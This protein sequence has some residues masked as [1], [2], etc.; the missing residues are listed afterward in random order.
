MAL[1][2]YLHVL[3]KGGVFVYV[4]IAFFARRFV[5][6]SYYAFISR[7][8]FPP[9]FFGGS[10]EPSSSG[11]GFVHPG[12]GFHFAISLIDIVHHTLSS[13]S[14]DTLNVLQIS[15]FFSYVKKGCPKVSMSDFE[16]P[17]SCSGRGPKQ[18]PSLT[19]ERQRLNSPK[20]GPVPGAQRNPK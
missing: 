11:K 3:L 1:F 8:I 5:S 19:N 20:S 7:I 13:T 6:V 17:W 16:G 14:H 2:G 9:I 18:R 15:L 4:C 12:H 10:P